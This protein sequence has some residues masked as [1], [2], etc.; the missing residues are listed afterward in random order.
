MSCRAGRVPISCR[1]R[2]AP[3][4][5]ATPRPRAAC[6][7]ASGR[8]RGSRARRRAMCWRGSRTCAA[9]LCRHAGGRR[10]RERAL[11]RRRR[12]CALGR[13]WRR[14]AVGR[15]GR[16]S[17]AGAGRAPT[18]PAMPRPRAAFS[19][20][21][22]RAR[23]SRAKRRATCW[24]GSRTCAARTS[25]TRWWATTGERAGG[26]RRRRCALGVRWRR[27]AVGRRRERRAVRAG[28]SRHVRVLRQW[29]HRHDR[30]MGGRDRPPVLRRDGGGG[31]R[32]HQRGGGRKRHDPPGRRCRGV[33]Q[34]WRDGIDGTIDAISREVRA[35]PAD[36][37]LR[38]AQRPGPFTH[39]AP[40]GPAIG[41]SRARRGPCRA[42]LRSTSASRNDYRCR[43]DR[44]ARCGC[45]RPATRPPGRRA[46]GLTSSRVRLR[47]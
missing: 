25:P 32:R 11:R 22:G 12:G 23:G 16:R 45:R 4:R 34:N 33:L 44:P 29:R 3:T 28:R 9:R 15:A 40:H 26:R 20:A 35:V 27:C 8:G 2:A 5:P 31:T 36:A 14:C 41:P 17:A 19:C 24:W 30:G 6:S 37:G 39:P 10:W 47:R 21:S 43:A 1:G 38:R 42:G 7:C 18:R 46:V 13:G